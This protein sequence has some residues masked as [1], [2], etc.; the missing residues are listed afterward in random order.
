M[1]RKVTYIL[2]AMLLL[3]ATMG[4]SVSKHYC[5]SR[6]VGIS[7]NSVMEYCCTDKGTSDC[8][9]NETEFF[10][11]DEDFAGPVIIENNQ[12]QELDILFPSMFVNLLD[13]STIFESE[14]LNF[15]ESPPTPNLH[16]K[17]SLFQSYLI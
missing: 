6:L 1:F 13:R 15:A 4:F 9:R 10:Q 8:C 12:I 5:S 16:T 2:I 11:F 3:I 14:I 17:L 7:I